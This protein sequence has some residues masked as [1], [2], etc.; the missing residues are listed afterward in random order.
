MKSH[1]NENIDLEYALCLIFNNVN[2]YIIG[3]NSIEESNKHKYFSFSSTKN[4]K[5]VLEKYTKLWDEIKNQIETIN[6]VE[7]N[8]TEPIKYRKNFMRYTFYSDDDNLPFGR[9]L[10]IPKYLIVIN[11]VLKYDNMYYP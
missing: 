1:Y 8:S 11:S 4:N 10:S 7:F 9:I 6:G 5:N 2:G 3:C